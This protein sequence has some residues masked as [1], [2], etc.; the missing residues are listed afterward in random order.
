MGLYRVVLKQGQKGIDYLAGATRGEG[1]P[2]GMWASFE[3][4]IAPNANWLRAGTTFD[5]TVYPSLRLYLGS[6]K[7]PDRYDHSRPSDYESITLSTDSN[8]LTVMPYDGELILNVG[9]IYSYNSDLYIN[10]VLVGEMGGNNLSTSLTASF[11][12]GDLV[13]IDRSGGGFGRCT[14]GLQCQEL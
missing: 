3:N 10:S 4:D 13:Y 9:T 5:E 6:N 2:L 14:G 11:K 7:V 1:C 12:K 8:N